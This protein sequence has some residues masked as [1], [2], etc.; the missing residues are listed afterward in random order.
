MVPKQNLH[1]VTPVLADSAWALLS[2]PT[3]YSDTLSYAE[4]GYK[5]KIM[6]QTMQLTVSSYV[7]STPKPRW[8]LLRAYRLN[9][10]G[11]QSQTWDV[12]SVRAGRPQ[13]YGLL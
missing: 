2:R 9:G 8:F 6:D 3:V 11:N 1:V 10:C 12:W 4:E 13:A 5:N 7:Q